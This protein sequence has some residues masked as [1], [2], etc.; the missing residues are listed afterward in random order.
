MQVKF[1]FNPNRKGVKYSGQVEPCLC[2]TY[3]WSQIFSFYFEL[4]LSSI[5]HGFIKTVLL[6]CVYGQFCVTWLNLPPPLPIHLVWTNNLKVQLLFEYGSD[7]DHFQN[8][9]P[10]RN[11]TKTPGSAVGFKYHMSN[12]VYINIYRVK[13]K[14][15]WLA[16]FWP[17][18]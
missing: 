1:Y 6:W 10:D 11:L 3:Y 5:K 4:K 15:V 13:Q 8:K 12:K 16:A 18:W 14:K 17:I 9:D 7:F 2:L